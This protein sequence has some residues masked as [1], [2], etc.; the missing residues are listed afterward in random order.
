MPDADKIG[1]F[2]RRWSKMFTKLCEG[3]FDSASLAKDAVFSLRKDLEHYDNFP[4][5]FLIDASERLESL[6][7]NPLF[8]PIHDW[9]EEDRYIRDLKFSYTRK[10]QPNQRAI[11]LAILAYKD[12]E[13]ILR[14]GG[15]I[16][17]N[18]DEALIQK[19]VRRIYD[20]NFCELV[21]L[22]LES[23]MDADWAEITH[24]LSE[25]DVFIDKHINTLVSQIAKKGNVK[26]LKI[27]SRFSLKKIISITDDVFSLGN[28][29]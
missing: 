14:N 21:P 24:R 29:K 13:H 7:D 28:R 16:V 8:L 1:K 10:F 3:Y 18:L 6:R 17:G 12:I 15:S 27:P 25:M 11:E 19:Y 23:Q 22:G 5:R 26:H 20:S 9:S 4:V 2:S